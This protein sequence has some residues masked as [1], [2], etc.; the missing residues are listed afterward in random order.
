MLWGEWMLCDLIVRREPFECSVQTLNL[1]ICSSDHFVMMPALLQY[2][3]LRFIETM[4]IVNMG[5]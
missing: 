3:T 1:I 2:H 4:S 5:L